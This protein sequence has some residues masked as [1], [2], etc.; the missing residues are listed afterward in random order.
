MASP[1]CS[2]ETFRKFESVA[3]N[4]STPIERSEKDYDCKG[5]AAY[6]L[7]STLAPARRSASTN[8]RLAEWQKIFIAPD[9]L[10][11]D[12]GCYT[13]VSPVPEKEA[14]GFSDDK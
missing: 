3:L 2:E 1:H 9:G 11:R 6:N 7:A 8:E 12:G 13:I 14:E 10:P 5:H 4:Y